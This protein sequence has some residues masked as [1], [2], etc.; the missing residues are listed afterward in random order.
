MLVQDENYLVVRSGIR[1]GE[2]NIFS[3]ES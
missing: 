2:R 1:W 3:Q